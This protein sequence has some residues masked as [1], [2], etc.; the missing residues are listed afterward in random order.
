MLPAEAASSAIGGAQ[1]SLRGSV[2]GEGVQDVT[3][4]LASWR[5]TGSWR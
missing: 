5:R 2:G 1:S 3:P 4:E